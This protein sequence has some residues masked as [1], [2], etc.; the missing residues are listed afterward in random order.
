MSRACSAN[1]FCSWLLIE[2][3]LIFTVQIGLGNFSDPLTNLKLLLA[4]GNQDCTQCQTQ[5]KPENSLC[6]F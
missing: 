6:A 5:K 1:S 2:S 3:K 4:N